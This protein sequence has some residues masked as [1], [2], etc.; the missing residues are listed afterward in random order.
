[1]GLER[2]RGGD[3]K[4]TIRRRDRRGTVN[5]QRREVEDAVDG[6]VE[7]V[8]ELKELLGGVWTH[9]AQV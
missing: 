2:G 9:L 3:L 6:F 8:L 1:M 7:T 4:E 5:R